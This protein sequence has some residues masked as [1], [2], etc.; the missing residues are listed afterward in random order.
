[1]SRHQTSRLRQRR[2]TMFWNRM[3]HNKIVFIGDAIDWRIALQFPIVTQ[4][5]PL[6]QVNLENIDT[7]WEFR[8]LFWTAPEL[9]TLEFGSRAHPPR[10]ITQRCKPGEAGVA[11]APTEPPKRKHLMKRSWPC[12]VCL[13]LTSFSHFALRMLS[14]KMFAAVYRWGRGR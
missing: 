5:F 6:L 14:R 12:G 8:S 10:H 13:S 4:K 7:N 11:H 1:M 9:G 2:K 3:N